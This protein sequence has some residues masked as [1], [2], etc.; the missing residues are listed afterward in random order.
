M[1]KIAVAVLVLALI[2]A[3]IASARMK[4]GSQTA[5]IV[6]QE[7]SA[8]RI[9][10]QVQTV[11]G[12]RSIVQKFYRKG[13]KQ[14]QD[15]QNRSGLEITITHGDIGKIW[16]ISPKEKTY[17]ERPITAYDR[18]NPVLDEIRQQMPNLKQTGTSVVNGR[19]CRE[20]KGILT[21]PTWRTEITVWI[22]PVIN[23]PVKSVSKTP[24]SRTMAGNPMGPFIDEYKNIRVEAQ[25]DSLF[26]IP[27]GYRKVQPPQ[28][29]KGMMGLP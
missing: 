15:R 6:Q 14:R 28:P 8:D 24:G 1:K 5:I 23:L 9:T 26:E 3:C 27:K 13:A 18:R 7:F 16:T 10:T 22:D 4:N 2:G 19:K 25:P 17:I 11:E 20:Y 12:D 21:D 29:T